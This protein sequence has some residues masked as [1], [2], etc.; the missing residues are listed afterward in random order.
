MQ[1]LDNKTRISLSKLLMVTLNSGDWEE[2]FAITECDDCP[3]NNPRFYKDVHWQN[4]GLKRGC[5]Q[6]IEYIL[7]EN[8]ENIVHIWKMDGVQT[9]LK[10][11]NSDTY[12]FIQ[13]IVNS[14]EGKS[15]PEPIPKN[16]NDSV[17][18]ALKDAEVLIANRGAANGYDRMHTALHSFLRQ[19]CENNNIPFSQKDGI[20]A[21]LPKISTHIKSLPDDGRNEKV[22]NML[23]SANSMLDSINYLRNNH[24][25]SHPTDELLTENDAVFSI[26][27]ARS[28]MTYIDGLLN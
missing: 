14:E 23:R 9:A 10:S 3:S 26:N 4:E 22:F 21:L 5:F 20:T 12:S 13:A 15:V 7:E 18:H 19:S 2:L 28:I 8:P 11:S 27:L 16:T 1:E 6:A 17:Y 25:L 24:S